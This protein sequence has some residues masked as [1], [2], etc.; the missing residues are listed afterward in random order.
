[1]IANMHVR[2][3]HYAARGPTQS[4]ILNT[5]AN[6]EENMDFPSAP[7]YVCSV[8]FSIIPKVAVIV[9]SYRASYK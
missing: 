2:M 6:L 5:P 9:S 1:M 8:T 7:S 3:F 4:A